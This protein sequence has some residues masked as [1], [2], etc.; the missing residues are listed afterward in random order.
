MLIV[1]GQGMAY[2][3]GLYTDNG[4][5]LRVKIRTAPQRLGPDGVLLDLILTAGQGFF[6]CKPQETADLPGPC[7]FGA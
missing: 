1:M 3:P 5:F 6:Y 7:E 4:V 2:A